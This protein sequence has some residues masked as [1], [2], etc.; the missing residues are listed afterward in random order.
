LFSNVIATSL[1]FL[2]T[3]SSIEL[4]LFDVISMNLIGLSI[5]CSLA[6]IILRKQLIPQGGRYKSVRYRDLLVLSFPVMIWEVAQVIVARSSVWIIGIMSNGDQ[7]AIYGTSFQLMILVS[8]PFVIVNNAIPHLVVRLNAGGQKSDLERVLRGLSTLMSLPALITV[9]IFLFFGGDILAFL[10]GHEYR[11]GATALIFLSLG[12]LVNVLS[13][14][15]GTA[16]IMTGNQK[17]LMK[18]TLTVGAGVIVMVFPLASNYGASGAAFG[19]AIGMAIQNALISYAAWK[20]VGV[21]T[22]ASVSM[23]GELKL[24]LTRWRYNND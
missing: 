10:F 6:F 22:Y 12:Q 1:F 5:S 9:V 7:V 18:I 21:R 15:C 23:L 2:L 16:L 3:Y 4:L 19:A 14:P 11:N 20:K 13:G 17:A 24:F 8:L